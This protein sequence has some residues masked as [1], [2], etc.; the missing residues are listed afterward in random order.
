[1]LFREIHILEKK[2]NERKLLGNL[3]AMS[4]DEDRIDFLSNDY[5]GLAR[6]KDLKISIDTSFLNLQESNKINGSTGSRLLSG[7]HKY[8]EYVEQ[9]LAAIF[10]AEA[11]LIFNSGYNANL[12]IL[13]CVPQK[14]DT[15]ICDELIHA[16]LI[17][18][19][20]LS[21]AKRLSFR[22]NDLED[23]EKKL[24]HAEGEKFVVVESIYSM[25]GDMCP[26]ESL[27]EVCEKYHAHI[28]LDEAHSTGL[29]GN[30]GNGILCE[31]NLHDK[32]FARIYTFGKGM[33]V[34]GACICGSQLLK[35]Y[36]INFARPFIYTTAMPLH[37]YVAIASAF[38]YL[39]SNTHE[40]QALFA[41]ID[42][43]KK[44][45]AKYNSSYL[46]LL[47][48]SNSAIQVITTSGNERA[49]RV[50]AQL[51]NK[52]FEVRAI[53]SPTVKAGEERLRICLHA[54]NT[55]KEIDD[56]TCTLSELLKHNDTI[57]L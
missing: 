1:M 49:K 29:W 10:K 39:Q 45:F 52:K 54:Y 43:F 18:G 53:L 12:S 35:D 2:L 23:L 44:L 48:P 25:D 21:F 26:L 22:H 3:R 47:Q 28:I 36:L 33:G 37:S 31:K 8:A 34:H 19:A 27:I 20:R 7:N 56:L 55:K 50:A 5:L 11:A 15:I 16:S 41:N 9:K 24:I 57:L 30:N 4:I 6:S 14:S 17:D 46:S 51:R 38:D 13:S 40:R 42:L 32:I